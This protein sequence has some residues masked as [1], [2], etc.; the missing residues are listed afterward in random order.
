MK[1]KHKTLT[2]LERRAVDWN[3]VILVAVWV[4]LTVW[5]CSKA[6][7]VMNHQPQTVPITTTVE[8]YR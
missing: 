4:L 1:R 6:W 2:E 3:T 5:A 8:D 7:R